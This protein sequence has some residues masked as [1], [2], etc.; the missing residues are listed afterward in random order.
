M[1]P[2]LVLCVLGAV[3][4]F[5]GAREFSPQQ[6]PLLAQF[7]TWIVRV[8]DYHTLYGRETVDTAKAS[9]NEISDMERAIFGRDE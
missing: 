9:Q 4:G 1:P 6:D 5:F 2:A 8:V 7:P 3:V